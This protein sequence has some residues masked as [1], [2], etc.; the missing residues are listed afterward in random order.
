MVDGRKEVF[1]GLTSV[2]K[3]LAAAL[4]DAG[5]TQTDFGKTLGWLKRVEQGFSEPFVC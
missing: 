2:S 3:D 5:R 4:R 1:L